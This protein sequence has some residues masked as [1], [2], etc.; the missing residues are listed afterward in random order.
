MELKGYKKRIAAVLEEKPQ[1][2]NC[3]KSLFAN[4]IF[5]Y[6][7]NFIVMVENVPYISLKNFTELPVSFETIRRSRQIIQN[8]CNLFLPTDPAVRKERNIKEEN[9]RNIEVREAKQES[10]I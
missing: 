4:Y 5:K 2:R 6:H 3:D 8:D 9:Y 1:T 7:N 10:L